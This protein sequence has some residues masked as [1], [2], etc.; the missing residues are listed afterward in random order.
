MKKKLFICAFIAVCLSMIAYSTTAF[1]TYEDTAK[2]VIIMGNIKI[3][4]QELAVP[5]GGG[6]P[7][8]FVDPIDVLPGTDVSKIVQVKNIGEQPA[9]VRISAAKAILLADGVTGD[10]DLSLVTYDLNTQYW[11]EQDGYFYYNAVLEAGETTEP[12]FTKVTFA[13]NMGNMY[14]QSEAMI[15]I[16]VQATQVANNGA[17]VLEAAGW[18]EALAE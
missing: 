3:E 4:L 1:F 9:W 7:V 6:E 8:P 13:A 15:Q 12:L 17:T 11:I 18:P 5:E 10:V 2:N 14:Q 16:N